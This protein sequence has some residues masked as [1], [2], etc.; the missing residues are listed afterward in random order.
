MSEADD[1]AIQLIKFKK[2]KTNWK[3]LM[4]ELPRDRLYLEVRQKGIAA[5]GVELSK[6]EVQN[7]YYFLLN[8]STFR[9]WSG[10]TGPQG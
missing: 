9:G 8:N 3:V 10:P 7:M 1:A 4:H 6:R 2:R 5:A